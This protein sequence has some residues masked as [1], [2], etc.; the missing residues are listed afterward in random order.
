MVLNGLGAM[1]AFGTQL[2]DAQIA[3]VVN[4]L[5]GNFANRHADALAAADVKSL[6]PPAQTRPTDL[7][8]R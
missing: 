2:D 4:F 7:Q 1:P 8:G 3:A 5:R 6:R